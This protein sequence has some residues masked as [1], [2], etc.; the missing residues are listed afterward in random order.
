MGR[1]RI[2][3][4]LK[5]VEKAINKIKSWETEKINEVKRIV[6]ETGRA[7]EAEATLRAPVD[8]GNLKASIHTD[9]ENKGLTALVGTPVDYAPHV[10]FGTRPHKIRTKKAKVL[11]NGKSFFGKEVNHPGTTAQPFLM[12]AFDRNKKKFVNAIRKVLNEREEI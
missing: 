4:E 7:I 6:A 2:D 8:Q 9:I 3:I 10:E 1:N 12:P 11:S 5:G